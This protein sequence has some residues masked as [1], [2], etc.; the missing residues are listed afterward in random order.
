MIVVTHQLLRWPLLFVVSSVF[1]QIF[2]MVHTPN[3]HQRWY[4]KWKI[5]WIIYMLHTH[6]CTFDANSYAPSVLIN[7]ISASE[8]SRMFIKSALLVGQVNCNFAK[9][10][11]ITNHEFPYRKHLFFERE[12]EIIFF[13]VKRSPPLRTHHQ[14]ENVVPWWYTG[15]FEGYCAHLKY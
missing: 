5:S 14:C 4:A 8:L 3:H 12:R 9:I 13:C 1:I 6:F 2:A 7:K 10:A 15:C 11:V